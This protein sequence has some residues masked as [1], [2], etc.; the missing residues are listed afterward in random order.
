MKFVLYPK[1]RYSKVVFFLGYNLIASGTYFYAKPILSTFMSSYIRNEKQLRLFCDYFLG[2]TVFLI[3]V[4]VS[5]TYWLDLN[6]EAKFKTPISRDQNLNP[7]KGPFP[8]SV[9]LLT[10]VYGYLALNINIYNY[11][12][13]F[14]TAQWPA[15]LI[16]TVFSVILC[17]AAQKRKTH[18][19]LINR[20]KF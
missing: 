8:T 5:L 11:W 14:L 17:M 20:R 12:S 16:I 18:L 3:W 15:L 7:L 4:T 10:P 6:L 2:S 1:N 9:A 13:E 19:D